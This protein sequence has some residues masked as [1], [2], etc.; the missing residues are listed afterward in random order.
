MKKLLALL[1]A[2]CMMCSV[3]AMAESTQAVELNWSDVEEVANDI[4]GA[5]VGIDLGLVIWAPNDYVVVSELPEEYT[6]KGIYGMIAKE[7]LTGAIALQYVDVKGAT[8]EECV[9]SIEGATDPKA[10]VINGFPCINFDMKEMDATCVAFATEQGRL[11]V[12]SFLPVSDE[13]FAA[14]STIMVA[15]IQNAPEE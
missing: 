9:A 10:M 11:F 3:A 14:V 4:G 2:L 7:D 15:S 5:F 13:E 6:E 8:L 1:V 12:L